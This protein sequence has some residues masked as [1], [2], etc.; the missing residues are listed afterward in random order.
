MDIKSLW[1]MNV[2]TQI[3]CKQGF[4]EIADKKVT[5]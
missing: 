4:G 3:W 5:K 1:K 2:G